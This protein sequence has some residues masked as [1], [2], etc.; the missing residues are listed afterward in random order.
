M[1]STSSNYLWQTPTDSN[2][3]NLSLFLHNPFIKHCLSGKLGQVYMWWHNTYVE[4]AVPSV[5]HLP[6]PLLLFLL[7]AFDWILTLNRSYFPSCTDLLNRTLTVYSNF[8]PR[9]YNLPQCLRH[10]LLLGSTL[11]LPRTM[12][13][14]SPMRLLRVCLDPR[15]M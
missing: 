6:L 9:I 12:T 10:D 4:A 5:P 11:R 14:P 2:G 13:S 3:L 15:T 1:F 7:Q 8:K